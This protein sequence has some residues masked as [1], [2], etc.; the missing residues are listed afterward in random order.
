MRKINICLCASSITKGSRVAV[1]QGKDYWVATVT[2]KGVEQSSVQYDEGTK[3]IA[4]NRSMTHLP[5]NARKITK[6]LTKDQVV[7][8]TA[9]SIKPKN[10]EALR[11][12]HNMLLDA[13]RGSVT[14]KELDSVVTKLDNV[15]AELDGYDRSLQKANL[16][17]SGADSKELMKKFKELKALGKVL[18]RDVAAFRKKSKLIKLSDS[19]REAINKQAEAAYDKWNEVNTEKVSVGNKLRLLGIRPPY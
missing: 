2:R 9:P 18:W 12:E 13:M 1:R 8:I 6:P 7:S 14:K 3:G 19:Q 17:T 5:D 11:K 10:I 4:T 15:R 16:I